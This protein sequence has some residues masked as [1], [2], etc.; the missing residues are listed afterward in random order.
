MT[1][2][3]PAR[4]N[5]TRL[6]AAG[7]HPAGPTAAGPTA[8]GRSPDQAVV[9]A[10]RAAVLE[11]WQDHPDRGRL[12]PGDQRQLV[13]TW[14]EDEL[15]GEHRRRLVHR[16]PALDRDA[17]VAVLRAVENAIWGLGRLQELL[18]LPG[19]ED[20]HIVG[21]DRPLLRLADGTV[22][23]RRRAG[24]GLRRRPDRPAAAH[25]RASRRRRS[26]RSP[27]RSRV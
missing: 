3:R 27:R 8:A 23:T 18:E 24:R 6:H 22:R 15:A 2:A 1:G 26:G 20:I 25:R 11:R 16:E 7:P 12:G 17:E 4:S 10:I 5:G 9:R 19:V 21:A 13:R 14:I